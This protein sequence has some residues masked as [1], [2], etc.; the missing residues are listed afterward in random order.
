MYSIVGTMLWSWYWSDGFDYGYYFSS[1]HSY[2][3]GSNGGAV[4]RH[5]SGVNV[6][7]VDGHAETVPVD[8]AYPDPNIY[9]GKNPYETG[10]T[11]M[12]DAENG[13]TRHGKAN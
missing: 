6:V 4:G 3:G 10:L 5:L 1:T 7:Y 8:Y 2:I 11:R 13:W 9:I 12:Q